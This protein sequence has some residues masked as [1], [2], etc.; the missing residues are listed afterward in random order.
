MRAGWLGLLGLMV[1]AAALATDTLSHVRETG[2]LRL[3]FRA[4][5]A[6][7]SYRAAD[8]SPAG[9]MVDLCRE[10][11]ESVK[12]S[13]GDAKLKVEFVEVTA[14]ERLEA[15][16]D[17]KIDV[18]CDPTSMTLSRREMVDFSVPTIIDGASVLYRTAGPGH[19]ADFDGKRIGV[20]Q[21]TT[22][23]QTLKTT[24]WQ[25]DIK[26][27]M[28]PVKTHEDGI[29]DL[30]AGKLDAYFA[31]RG[32]LV[33]YLRKSRKAAE[34]KLE[35]QYYTFETYALAIPRDDGKLRLLVDATLANLY[36]TRSVQR[37]YTRSFGNT[38]PDEF[39]RALFVIHGIAN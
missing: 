15:V 9:Y 8:G 24:L 19:L 1:P 21:G 2:T 35:D 26:A 20:L 11:S 10:V 28:V 17:G 38:T 31:D 16:R 37:I 7:Y 5:A 29:K 22:T 27:Q 18:L 34:L 32:I 3:G 33:H 4:D 6:P 36:R 25:L 13:V 30:S 23:E 39:I 14:A 12:K